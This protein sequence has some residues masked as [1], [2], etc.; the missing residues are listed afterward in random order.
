MQ[1]PTTEWAL[2]R[3]APIKPSGCSGHAVLALAIVSGARPVP[4]PTVVVAPIPGLP[5]WSLPKGHYYGII[6]GRRSPTVGTSRRSA[7]S[8]G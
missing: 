3:G 1:P 7:R 5:A 2:Q 4:P 8:S 6:T